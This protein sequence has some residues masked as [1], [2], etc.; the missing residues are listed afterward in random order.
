MGSQSMM[1]GIA[2]A[3]LLAQFVLSDGCSSCSPRVYRFTLDDDQVARVT[4]G[5][6]APTMHGCNIVCY[7]VR[8]QRDAGSSPDGGLPLG[9]SPGTPVQSCSLSDHTLTCDWGTICNV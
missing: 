1:K 5:T 4:E 3:V 7:E 2:T 8:Q 9:T 6:A